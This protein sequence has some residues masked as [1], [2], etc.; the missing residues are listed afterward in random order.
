MRT[1]TRYRN[2]ARLVNTVR[3]E[4][5]FSKLLV[6]T[7]LEARRCGH[8][9]FKSSLRFGKLLGVDVCLL[10]PP[11]EIFAIEAPDAASRTS[12][13]EHGSL[14]DLTPPFS[15]ALYAG[16]FNGLRLISFLLRQQRTHLCLNS[17][18]LVRCMLCQCY[19][20]LQDTKRL[21]ALRQCRALRNQSRK[22]L[23]PLRSEATLGKLRSKRPNLLPHS[24]ISATADPGEGHRQRKLC[25]RQTRRACRALSLLH[26][27][28]EPAGA[29]A[30]R[31]RGRP[32]RLC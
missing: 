10:P 21:V 28:T 31:H 9:S 18:A 13:K 29:H 17:I 19:G 32:P 30:G 20:L 16:N 24:R 15:Q 14:P 27:W 6:K 26:G 4:T 1:Q 5:V 25:S 11:L 8:F 23:L 2:P 22:L 12:S 7:L 3:A